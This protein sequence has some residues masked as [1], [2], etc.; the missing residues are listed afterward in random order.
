LASLKEKI[1][2]WKKEKYSNIGTHND[3]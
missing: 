2:F 3:A 1:D